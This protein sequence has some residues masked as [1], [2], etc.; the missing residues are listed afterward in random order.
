MTLE[1]LIYFMAPVYDFPAPQSF[2]GK[3]IYNPY[4]SMDSNQWKKANFH[5]HAHA[6]AD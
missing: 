6:W 2:S 4:E 3:K 5:F 1:L